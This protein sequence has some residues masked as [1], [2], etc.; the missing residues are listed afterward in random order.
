MLTPTVT[1]L[2]RASAHSRI[3]VVAPPA[4]APRGD[5]TSPIRLG[6]RRSTASA[7][8]GA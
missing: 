2:T 4:N 6:D 1:E 3:R 8:T 5:R 7:T